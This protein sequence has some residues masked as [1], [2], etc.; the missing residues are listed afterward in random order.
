MQQ[1]GAAPDSAAAPAPVADEWKPLGQHPIA[2]PSGSLLTDIGRRAA[3]A[4]TEALGGFLGLPNAV[5]QGVDWLG[6]KAGAD[7]GAQ[8]A[9]ESIKVPDGRPLMPDPQTAREMAYATTGATEYQPQTYWGRI[10]QA[11]L[12]AGAS[13]LPGGVRMLPAMLGGGATSEMAGEWAG[14]HGWSPGAQFVARLAGFMPGSMLANK[15]SNMAVNTIRPAGGTMDPQAARL[16]DAAVNT[17]EIPLSVGQTTPN[18][19]TR[20]IY[21]ES[22]KMPL[23][24]GEHF[25]SEQQ[26]AF[27]RAIS[28][29]F[30]EDAT[31]ITPEVLNSARDRL[32]NEF[33]TIAG[34]TSIRADPQF[35]TDLGRVMGSIPYAG[36][37]EAERNSIRRLAQDMVANFDNNGNFSGEA[38]QRITRKNGPFSVAQNSGS[39]NVREFSNQLRAVLDDALERNVHPDDVAALANARSQWKAMRTVEPLTT[40]RD[41]QGAA[42]PSTG[43]IKPGDL[44][45]AVNQSYKRNAL[46]PVGVV[47]LKDLAQI[48]QRFLGNLPDSGTAARMDARHA[49]GAAGAGFGALVAGEHIL[50]LPMAASVA[51]GAGTLGSGAVANWALRQPSWVQRE[52]AASLNPNG[53]QFRKPP[54]VPFGVI[55]AAQPNQAAP[56]GWSPQQ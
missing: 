31:K 53:F 38:Y 10:G 11:A 6:R 16:A 47:P 52:I 4:G 35:A 43:D 30:G 22:G 29:T 32:S 56:F 27:N 9:V 42:T 12:N 36:L 17:Y 13:G 28:R 45:G 54:I 26:G 3:T 15:A 18:R 1:T 40:R 2:G 49:L 51:A 7:I 5:A 41:A 25:A 33:S 8:R 20:M 44:I 37:G 55:N 46:D 14:E 34:R 21:S 24:G 50:G 23:S 39:P 48:G 19:F